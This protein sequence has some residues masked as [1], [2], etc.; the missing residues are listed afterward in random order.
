M[1]DVLQRLAATLEARKGAAPESS[2]TASLYDRGTDAILKKIGEEATE[3]VLAGKAAEREQVVREAADLLYH[4]MVL[5]AAAD[6]GPDPVLA[7]LERRFAQS[8]HEEK[9]GRG[10]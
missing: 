1:S 2:Y 3:L 6:I 7:E 9:A 5:L 8:G 4:V 10:A